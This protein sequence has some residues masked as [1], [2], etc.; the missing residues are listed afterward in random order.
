MVEN[1]EIGVMIYDETISRGIA[2]HFDE[3]IMDIAFRLE[4]VDGDIVWQQKTEDG[5]VTLYTEP[6][7]GF[8]QR[9]K[10]G[11]M[12]LLPGESQL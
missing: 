2:E 1:T 6:N 7:T 11:F 12:S 9:F 3:N 4:I 5:V 10:V 8:W